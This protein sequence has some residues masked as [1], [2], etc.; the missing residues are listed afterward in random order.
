MGVKWFGGL[1]GRGWETP[2]EKMAQCGP[3]YGFTRK[4]HFQQKKKHKWGFFFFLPAHMQTAGVWEKVWEL[5]NC[6]IWAFSAPHRAIPHRCCR[7]GAVLSLGRWQQEPLQPPPN[8]G[9]SPFPSKMSTSPI[10]VLNHHQPLFGNVRTQTLGI[11]E[12]GENWRLQLWAA[13]F[14]SIPHCPNSKLPG[15]E[16]KKIKKERQFLD[17]D[18]FPH[19][20]IY[21][22]WSKY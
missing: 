13:A 6:G 3:A 11:T 2:R 9:E 21:R 7:D 1:Q 22:I 5:G 18:F 15:R 10:S 19:G 8:R 17:A 12:G 14:P 4:V 16:K 20:V